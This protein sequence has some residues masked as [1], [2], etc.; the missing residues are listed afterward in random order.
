MLEDFAKVLAE[1]FPS[2]E[3]ETARRFIQAAHDKKPIPLELYSPALLSGICQAD[4]LGPLEFHVL[5]GDGKWSR[6]SGF[7]LVLSQS[8]DTEH[9]DSVIVSHGYPLKELEKS[10]GERPPPSF[11]ADIVR[12][13]LYNLF[14]LPRS[15]KAGFLDRLVQAY[16]IMRG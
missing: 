10:E 15:V 1:V 8:C 5:N 14:Y 13:L 6:T 4:V 7:G 3:P 2:V 9:D 16:K 12:N 11:I